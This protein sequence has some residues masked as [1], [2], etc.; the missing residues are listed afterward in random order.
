MLIDSGEAAHIGNE[1]LFSFELAWLRQDGFYE[2]VRAEWISVSVGS[3]PI[4][5]WQNKIR[6]IRQFLRGWAKHKSGE[7]RIFRDKLLLLIDELDI[8]AET[9]P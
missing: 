4:E 9:T 2:M 7:Y 5:K 1:S 6:H 3:T 8:R